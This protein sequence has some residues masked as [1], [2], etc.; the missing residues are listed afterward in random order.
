[1]G[2]RDKKV[3][4]LICH[5]YGGYIKEI[6][7]GYA[8][9]YKLRNRAGLISLIEDINGLIRNPTRLLQMSKLCKK[10]DIELNNSKDLTFN[11]G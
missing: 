3:L 10:F 6:S 7:N 11:N 4:S 5:K 1:M 8:F 2:A 9:K